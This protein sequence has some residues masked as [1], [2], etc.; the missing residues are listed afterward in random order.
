MEKKKLRR[1]CQGCGRILDVENMDVWLG[2][3]VWENT[4]RWTDDPFAAEIHQ[5]YTEMWL[6]G[7]CQDARRDE[8]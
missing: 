2:D 5:D 1:T 7:R 4:V 6:C 8:I 3:E